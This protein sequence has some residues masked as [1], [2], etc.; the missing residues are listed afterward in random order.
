M[1]TSVDDGWPYAVMQNTDIGL[2]WSSSVPSVQL[3]LTY[4]RL[5]TRQ[6]PE[7]GRTGRV[8]HFRPIGPSLR[9]AGSDFR[10]DISNLLSS[11]T[12]RNS[13]LRRQYKNLD[14]EK[15]GEL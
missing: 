11:V 12:R 15:T 10:P 2:P 3:R 9:R 14:F 4:G 8:Q 1:I 5:Q 13:K 7:C 6:S